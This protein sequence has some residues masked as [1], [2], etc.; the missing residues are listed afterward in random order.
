M[1]LEK[2]THNNYRKIYKHSCHTLKY[3]TYGIKVT[4]FGRLEESS[5]NSL[6]RSILKII[7]KFK[8]KESIKFWN[9]VFLNLNLTKL[10]SESRMGK[11]K[12]IIINKA[13]FLR[14]GK[15]IFEFE[16]LTFQQASLILFNMQKLLHLK[17]NLVRK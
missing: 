15:V 4:S 3:G 1:F 14:P 6:N 7:K 12:G 8:N 2:K 11:G 17:M 5:I 10:S 13:L 9:L 16:G